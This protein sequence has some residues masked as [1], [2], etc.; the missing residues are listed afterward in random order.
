ML[1]H[2]PEALERINVLR[3]PSLEATAMFD[4]GSLDL[5]QLDAL[6]T[7]DGVAAD[8]SA[9]CVRVKLGGLIGGDDLVPDFPG[10]EQA[11][12]HHFGDNFEVVGMGWKGWRHVC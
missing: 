3:A 12:R 6:H 1:Q 9:W 4:G 5:V 7:F 10:V 2:C 8:I 11:V